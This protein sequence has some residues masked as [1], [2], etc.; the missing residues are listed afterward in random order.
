MTSLRDHV[1]PQDRRSAAKSRKH[2]ENE[3]FE[4]TRLPSELV[5]ILPVEPANSFSYKLRN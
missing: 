4:T 5:L 1:T 2:M 3:G